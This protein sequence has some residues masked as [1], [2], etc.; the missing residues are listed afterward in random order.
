MYSTSTCYANL[1]PDRVIEYCNSWLD[2]RNEVLQEKKEKCIEKLMQRRCGWPWKRRN[3]TREEALDYA[4]SG[5]RGDS[6]DIAPF[7]RIEM[8]GSYWANR[9][10]Q[11]LHLASAAKRDGNT[12][13]VSSEMA[14]CLLL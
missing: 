1:N 9:V 7:K 12:V 11:L 2:T 6:F 5:V 3:W 13:I 4:M 10:Q 8:H 14:E